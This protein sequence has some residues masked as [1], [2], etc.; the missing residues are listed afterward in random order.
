MVFMSEFGKWTFS[1]ATSKWLV[2]ILTILIVVTILA[3]LNKWLR[4]WLQICEGWP[5]KY[6]KLL[7]RG[8]QL[9]KDIY[10]AYLGDNTS[11][12]KIKSY[13]NRLEELLLTETEDF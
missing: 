2:Y 5:Q 1:E 13:H 8:T 6:C 10:S 3:Q 4:E 9:K 12:E 11:I 7:R